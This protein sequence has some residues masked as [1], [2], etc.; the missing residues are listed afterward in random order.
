ML[1]GG[2]IA[3]VL[4]ERRRSVNEAVETMPLDF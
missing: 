2:L 1:G 4:Q 3:A